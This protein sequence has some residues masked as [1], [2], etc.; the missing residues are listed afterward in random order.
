MGL[1]K[2]KTPEQMRKRAEVK[3]AFSEAKHSASIQ[4]AKRQGAKRATWKA[5]LVKDIGKGFNTLAKPAPQRRAGPR[6]IP[7]PAY[8]GP[9]P[10]RRKTT[11]R[12][13]PTPTHVVHYA[14]PKPRRKARKKRDPYAG[15][16]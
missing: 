3:R 12:R 9:R 1:F 10:K 15:W 13:Q 4:Q 16:L 6:R 5:D 7:Q 11:R 8:Y 14:K 2:E